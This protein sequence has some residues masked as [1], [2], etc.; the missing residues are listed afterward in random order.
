[1]FKLRSFQIAFEVFRGLETSSTCFWIRLST[2]TSR[3]WFIY[4][5]A[6][7]KFCESQQVPW[8]FCMPISF[9]LYQVGVIFLL[10]LRSLSLRYEQFSIN[11]S[12]SVNCCPISS[13]KFA[14]HLKDCALIYANVHSYIY[15][16]HWTIN[17]ICWLNRVSCAESLQLKEQK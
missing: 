15:V 9:S 13:L 10:K 7:Q 2:K 3:P 11:Y 16:L 1:M 17:C 6:W 8:I 4:P 14:L 12:S 5:I